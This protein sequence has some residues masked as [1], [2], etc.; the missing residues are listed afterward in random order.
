MVFRKLSCGHVCERLF[1]CRWWG[2]S[3]VDGAIS[4]TWVCKSGELATKQR[5]SMISALRSSCVFLQWYVVTWQLQVEIIPWFSWIAF[6][7][8]A[9]SQQ[10]NEARMG[11]NVFDGVSIWCFYFFIA[12]KGHCQYLLYFY[13]FKAVMST[14]KYHWVIALSD[15]INSQR[16]ISTLEHMHK[17]LKYKDILID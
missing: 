1:C 5:P 4:R 9:L 8:N 3:T 15:C 7:Q 11:S 16:K 12:I 6:G 10:Q 13:F 14:S 17:F 2:Q